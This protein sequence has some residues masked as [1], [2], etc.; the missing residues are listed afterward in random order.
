MALVDIAYYA[1]TFGNVVYETR[2]K[3][4]YELLRITSEM[5]YFWDSIELFDNTMDFG[6]LNECSIVTLSSAYNDSRNTSVESK[7][8]QYRKTYVQ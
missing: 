1:N 4:L 6:P 7:T 5:Y 8:S 2:G 3:Q